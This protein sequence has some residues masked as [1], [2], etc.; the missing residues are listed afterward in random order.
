MIKRYNN[1][2]IDFSQVQC[3][4][5]GTNTIDVT[6]INKK[7]VSIKTDEFN[8]LFCGRFTHAKEEEYNKSIAHWQE[9]TLKDMFN[10]WTTK[11]DK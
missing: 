4:E 1:A 7:E 5:K 8:Y 6:F 9:E 2:I 11:G 10:I 3:I